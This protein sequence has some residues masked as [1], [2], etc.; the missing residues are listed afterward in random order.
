[1]GR[2]DGKVALVSGAASGLGRADAERLVAEGASV[3]LTDLDTA[4][5]EAVAKSLG[6]AAHF[7]SHDVSDEDSWRSAIATAEDRFGPLDVVVNNAG[8]LA[9]ASVED[10][11]VEQWERVI[12]TNLTGAYAVTRAVS[13]GM[14]RRRWGRVI[15]VSSVVGLMGNSGTTILTI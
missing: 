8:I 4:A 10:T 13:R 2:V 15:S 3:L 1:M 5:G 9:M 7:V 12:R 6:D 14:M 11:S